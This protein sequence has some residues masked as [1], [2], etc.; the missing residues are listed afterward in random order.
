[1]ARVF[2][3]GSSDGLGLMAAQLLVETGHSAVLHARNPARAEDARRRLQGCDAIVVGDL[4]SLDETRS[5]AEQVNRLGRFDA[6][7]HNAGVGLRERLTRTAE[8]LPHVFAIN[9]LAPYLLTALIEKP[10]RLV[11]LSSGMH[12]GADHGLDDLDWTRRRWHGSAA[13]AES[14]LCD[15]LLAFA[16]ARRWPS[17]FSNA[18]NPG[19]VATKMG[20]PGAP[21]D[22]EDGRRTQVWLAVSDD[23]EAR[24]SGKYFHH[25]R[26]QTA[27]PAVH[28]VARQDKLLELCQRFS[29]VAL[30]DE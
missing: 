12:R 5:L 11:Y 19:W 30:A 25:L 2:I 7:I 21:D 29:G 15:V 8:G 6:V 4:A 16:A 3:T 22:E 1:M 14:K 26:P 13:Y 27:D 24:I 20:G 23:P 28:D 18:V 9:V 17:V 10:S